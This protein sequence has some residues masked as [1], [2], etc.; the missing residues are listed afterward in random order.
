MRLP[1]RK[2]RSHAAGASLGLL[3]IALS[4]GPLVRTE[5]ATL[6][7]RS[8]ALAIDCHWTGGDGVIVTRGGVAIRVPRAEVVRIDDAPPPEPCPA[9]APEPTT[10]LGEPPA[11]ASPR[12]T[13]PSTPAA[14]APQIPASPAEASLTPVQ[15]Q[16]LADIRQFVNGFVIDYRLPTTIEVGVMALG[17]TKLTSLANVGVSHSLGRLLVDPGLLGA[18]IQ[19]ALIAKVLALQ[20]GRRTLTAT[21]LEDYERQRRQENFEANAKAVEILV[22]V[23]GWP[24]RAALH[25]V[26]VWLLALHRGG[27]PPS[28]GQP[29]ACDQIVEL[30]ARFPEHREWTAEL[31]CTPPPRAPGT[32]PARS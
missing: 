2:I 15:R 14:P 3:G 12:V 6:H 20:Y 10:T 17:S 18:P 21:S 7:L 24:E 31:S 27:R 9:A 8:G 11:P 16:A 13:A 30:H 19:D 28:S 5:A 22:R 26:H 29:S 1:R 4:L 25:S 23:K 32:A